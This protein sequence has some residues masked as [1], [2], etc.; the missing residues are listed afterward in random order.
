[1]SGTTVG[2]VRTDVSL[3]GTNL[4]RDTENANSVTLL[5]FRIEVILLISSTPIL[6][7]RLTLSASGS[8]S[9]HKRRSS[10]A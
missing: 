1:M 6:S 2:A 7:G 10:P 5:P 8:L 4:A 9:R 3:L